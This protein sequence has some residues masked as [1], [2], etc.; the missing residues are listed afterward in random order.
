[1][2]ASQ[3]CQSNTELILHITQDSVAAK[4]ENT[5]GR[6]GLTE[7]KRHYLCTT[8][9]LPRHSNVQQTNVSFFLQVCV[10]M[11]LRRP[12][13]ERKIRGLNPAWNRIFP[14]SSH[15]SDLKICTPLATLPGAWHYK[16]V[17]GLV[18]LVSVY[19]DWVRWKVGS[20]ISVSVWQHVKLY[21]QIRP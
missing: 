13:R 11:W 19:C 14:G 2:D 9:L 8:S 1:M 15:I 5:P 16:S 4:Q 7:S 20:A 10:Y 6:P 18:G 3:D 12:P 17:L 21:E